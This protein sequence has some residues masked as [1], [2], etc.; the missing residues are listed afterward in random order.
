MRSRTRS[1]ASYL[2][3]DLTAPDAV[4]LGN[5]Q[6]REVAGSSREPVAVSDFNI[7]T[8]RADISSGRLHYTIGGSN[9]RSSCWSAEIDP[10]VKLFN[11]R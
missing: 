5:V 3:D 2:A 7:G 1:G 8:A 11:S 4:V 6:A 10:V 9:N